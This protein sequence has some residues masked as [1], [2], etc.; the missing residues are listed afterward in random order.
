MTDGLLENTFGGLVSVFNSAG[1]CSSY[2]PVTLNIYDLVWKKPATTGGATATTTTP[3]IVPR[4]SR[5]SSCHVEEQC[6]D[7]G[8]C[9][10]GIQTASCERVRV[11]Y[12]A[13]YV[14]SEYE[15]AQACE[16]AAETP[17][18]EE[19]QGEIPA[20]GEE[21]TPATENTNPITGNVVAGQAEENSN[22]ITG[23]VIQSTLS[24]VKPVPLIIAGVLLIGGIVAMF[25]FRK[26]KR[27]NF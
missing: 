5:S 15:T 19:N 13:S 3:E 4:S 1:D 11:C 17:Q 22:P 14:L 27:E 24:G 6:G 23:N 26:Y 18:T 21:N 10:E 16:V 12:Q 20:A 8:E 25:M 9:V 2:T 7:F